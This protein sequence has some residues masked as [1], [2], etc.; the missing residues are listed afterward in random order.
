MLN[1]KS[2]S[3]LTLFKVHRAVAYKTGPLTELQKKF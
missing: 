1:S 2:L 3:D